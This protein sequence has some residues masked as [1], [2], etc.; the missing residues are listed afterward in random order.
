MTV[1]IS[2][3]VP[4]GLNAL[5]E[6]AIQAVSGLM[7]TN[8]SLL[9]GVCLTFFPYRSILEITLWMFPGALAPLFQNTQSF[10]RDP[11]IAIKVMVSKHIFIFL[12]TSYH[13]K[14][15]N[16]ALYLAFLLLQQS[17][18][19]CSVENNGPSR[20]LE[21]AVKILACGLFSQLKRGSFLAISWTI[22]V[23]KKYM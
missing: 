19:N 16:C 7:N 6:L 21:N 15:T 22:L 10:D 1:A 23:S 8:R 12:K 11:S 13:L 9:L 14:Q 4:Q 5:M 17:I 2:R 20:N 18:V 3:V